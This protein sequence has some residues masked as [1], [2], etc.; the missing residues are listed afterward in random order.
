MEVQ[1]FSAED[2]RAKAA[3]Q[4]LQNQSG[5]ATADVVLSQI[6]AWDVL[7]AGGLV[8][9]RPLALAKSHG[10]SIPRISQHALRDGK[11]YQVIRDHFLNSI[12]Q[13][14]GRVSAFAGLLQPVAVDLM[15]DGAPEHATTIHE[16]TD[17]PSLV[18]FA[19]Q[20]QQRGLP[21]NLRQIIRWLHGG[22]TITSPKLTKWAKDLGVC[23]H[24]NIN[25]VRTYTNVGTTPQELRT[26]YRL[27]LKATK[28]EL[29]L[30]LFQLAISFTAAA[31][32]KLSTASEGPRTPVSLKELITM[33]RSPSG[34]AM[35][36]F[37]TDFMRWN[38]E[39]APSG[40]SDLKPQVVH[41]LALMELHQYGFRYAAGNNQ[42][43]LPLAYTALAKEVF[44]QRA[45]A[46]AQRAVAA[47]GH[48][49]TTV[50]KLA[51]ALQH[52][53]VIKSPPGWW[54][55]SLFTAS[56]LT[57]SLAGAQSTPTEGALC[58][59]A[60]H[61]TFQAAERV[62]TDFWGSL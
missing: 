26:H 48:D 49:L 44:D 41:L 31:E 60:S 14:R 62:A 45:V 54:M 1:L 46:A 2:I 61:C 33:L 42:K 13:E 36:P 17:F 51:D 50:E 7:L 12:G 27:S 22:V 28:Y 43:S 4:W 35:C 15:P 10:I 3:L 58:M 47:A 38:I 16:V 59:P 9:L 6:A 34:L 19:Q 30:Q 32:G 29:Q 39:L 57:A 53:P 40:L 24:L 55:L 8:R 18:R 21:E 23:L 20:K 52:N 56:P 11:D 5:Q 25:T 37:G